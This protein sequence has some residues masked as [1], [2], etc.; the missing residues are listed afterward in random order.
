[1][2]CPVHIAGQGDAVANGQSPFNVILEKKDA[3]NF[4]GGSVLR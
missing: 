3:G 2:L 4:R 1:M